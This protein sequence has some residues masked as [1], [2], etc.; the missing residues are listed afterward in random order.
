MLKRIL[1]L[2]NNQFPNSFNSVNI[3]S[4]AGVTKVSYVEQ[5][6]LSAINAYYP[7]INVTNI[8]YLNI[9]QQF[10]CYKNGASNGALIEEFDINPSLSQTYISNGC[11]VYNSGT[12]TFCRRVLIYVFISKTSEDTRTAFVSQTVFP[13]L[14]DYAKDYLSSPSYS[15]ANHKFCFINILPT[16]ITAKM[17]LRNLASLY[18]TGMDYVEVFGNNSLIVNTI[19]KNIKEFLKIFS[20]NFNANY[21]VKND[22]YEEENYKI[23]FKNKEFIWKTGSLVMTKLITKPD[24]SVDFQG[25]S[26]KFYWI[27]TLPMS[28][29]AYNQGYNIDYSDY[30]NFITSYKTKFGSSS[31]KM[32][33]C[34]VLL[35]YIKKYFV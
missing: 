25:S 1:L 12:N 22:I 30:T 6:I 10:D 9:E 3:N 5:R 34:E 17:I 29:F 32:A 4:P 15:I 33:R 13:T 27:E 18:V 28:M 23:D 8:E 16:K 21:D 19:P 35:D 11:Y 7:R 20:S 26:E 2:N 24:G 31:K 14:L